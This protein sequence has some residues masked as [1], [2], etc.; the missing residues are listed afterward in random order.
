MTQINI[1][2]TWKAID[3]AEVNISGVWKD[4][5][6]IE[7]NVG[8]TWKVV[9]PLYALSGESAIDH[10]IPSGTARAGI[11]INADGTID[12]RLGDTYT[13][14]DAATDW[15]I[16]NGGSKTDVR[17]RCTNS[18]STLA[19]GS[20]ATGSWLSAPCEWYVETT[21]ASKTLSLSVEISLDTG[22]STHDTGAYS[23]IADITV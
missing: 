2:G 10:Q 20:S 5:A 21:G 3:A 11:R 14:I 23:G 16:P 13:Q 15:I 6:T 22:T 19:G 12:K 4:V 18:G 9:W 17:F 7:A 1:G 8:G